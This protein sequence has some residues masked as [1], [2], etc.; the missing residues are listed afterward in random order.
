MV[1]AHIGGRVLQRVADGAAAR[2]CALEIAGRNSYNFSMKTTISE[3]GQ[4]TI[5]KAVRQ[6]LGLRAGTIIDVRIDRGAF[7]G[8]KVN[9]EDVFLK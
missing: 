3:K 9:S 4:I 5:P 2:E 6:A 8:T 7:V 1:Y